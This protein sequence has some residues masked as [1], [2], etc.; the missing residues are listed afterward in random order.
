[1]RIV[2]RFKAT[3]SKRGP[4]SFLFAAVVLGLFV[5]VAAAALVSLVHLVS[6]GTLAFSEWSRWGV[7]V[8][9]ISVPVGMT[10]SWL[11]D[12]RWGPA[13]SGGGITE[14]MI[15]LGLHGG[16]LPTGKIVPKILASAATLGTG[17]SGGREGPIAY[18]GASIG[19]SLAR[20]TGFDHDRIRSLVAA[21]AGAGIGASFN[22]PIAGMMF[23][24]EVILGSFAIRHLNAVVIA[25]VAA[26]VTMELIVGEESI[27]TSPAHALGSP[28]EL[29]LYATLAVLA[30]IIGIVYLRALDI[31]E[32]SSLPSRLP[33]WS[34]PVIFGLSVGL[35]GVVW[36]ESLGTGQNFLSELLRLEGAGSYVWW[37]LGLV[38]IAKIATS[39]LTRA[40]GGSAGTFMPA[41][42]IGGSIGAAFAI[43]MEQGFGFDGLDTGAF[44]VV[45]MAA[46]FATIAR[47][48]L[49]SVIIVFELTGN[50]EL[51]LPLMLGAA[52][53]TYLGDRLHPESV[54]T[55]PLVRKGITL[56]KSEDIDLLD[57]VMVDSVMLPHDGGLHRW[58]T[59]A[60]AAE[61]FDATAHHGA[62]VF[63]DKDRLVGMITLSDIRKAGGPSMTATVADAMSKEVI[64]ITPDMPV[65][66]A[67]ARMSSLGIGRVPVVDP[68]DPKHVVGM[69]RRISVVRAYEQALSMSKGR[70]LYRERSRIRSQPGADFFDMSINT[71]STLA[72]R[73]VAHIP[74]PADI[75]LVSVQRGTSVLVPH[76]D[77]M[78]RAGDR[79]TV[80]GTPEACDEVLSIPP[81]DT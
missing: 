60:E 67:L 59:L 66:S 3:L 73:D 76:G 10:A 1:M 30:V 18:I 22:A 26:A 23:A 12:K 50:Y 16:Y 62:P 31:T 55:I 25:S 24:M 37:G 29:F 81:A 5:G 6:Q 52:L 64:T 78:I 72:N 79:L 32:A 46:T 9:A 69:F 63:N 20:Y 61:F 11:I 54:Y 40:G 2:S 41:L 28:A 74:W 75:V 19:S 15:G 48:P 13:I 58:N 49:T 65:S 71:A 38:A 47:A 33:R 51:V 56:P 44:A 80:F 45:G 68:N 35:L 7:W 27:L 36:P 70:E 21:G 14:T 39:A 53:A 8:V 42:V 43:V 57:T 4:A 17:G 34:R 77:T